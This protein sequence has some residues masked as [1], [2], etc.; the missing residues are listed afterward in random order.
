MGDSALEY[1]IKVLYI[2]WVKVLGILYSTHI[3]VHYYDEDAYM[4][5]HIYVHHFDTTSSS[6]YYLYVLLLLCDL[7][8]LILLCFFILLYR[9]GSIEA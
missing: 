4:R 9:C 8:L 7:I 3:D 2:L 1:L 5:T 6:Y